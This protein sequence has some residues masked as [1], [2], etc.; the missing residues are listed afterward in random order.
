MQVRQQLPV[1]QHANT[2]EHR[3]ED[4][5]DFGGGTDEIVQI[6]RKPVFQFGVLGVLVEQVYQLLFQRLGTFPHETQVV[7]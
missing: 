7:G 4:G 3:V 6:P 1:I 2:G 5:G